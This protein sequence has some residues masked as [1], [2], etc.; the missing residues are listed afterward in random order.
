M[1]FSHLLPLPKGDRRRRS[2]A[3]S[4]I[5]PIEGQSEADPVSTTL[6]PAEST[7]D[8]RI[9]TSTPPMPS[10]LATRD[11][12]PKGM[13]AAQLQAVYLTT[14]FRATQTASLSP[15]DSDLFSE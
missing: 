2:K 8:L 14:L 13:E 9:D 6:R 11:Q 1:K 5:G 3:R 10:P 7:P 12:E 15:I 4:E